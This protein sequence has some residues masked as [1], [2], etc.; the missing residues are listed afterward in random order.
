MVN[1]PT[2]ERAGLI[3]K[4]GQEGVSPEEITLAIAGANFKSIRAIV[5]MV[6]ADPHAYDPYVDEVAVELAFRGDAEAWDAM[7]HY[8]AL[9]LV[10]RVMVTAHAGL[11]NPMWPGVAPVVAN[12][13]SEGGWVA[14]L[15][16]QLGEN[17]KRFNR[18]INKRTQRGRDKIV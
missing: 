6:L 11:E 17:P 10:N 1:L 4:L 13:G 18:L 12:R 14:A 16:N 7:S 15:S 9:A 8:E 2:P 3:I 5:D